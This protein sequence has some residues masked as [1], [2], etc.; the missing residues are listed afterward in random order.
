MTSARSARKDLKD[1]AGHGHIMLCQL[2]RFLPRG[3]CR[4]YRFICSRYIVDAC[5]CKLIAVRHKCY[6]V[7]RFRGLLPKLVDF[8][9]YICVPSI[10]FVAVHILDACHVGSSLHFQRRYMERW[11]Y[12]LSSCEWQLPGPKPLSRKVR[13]KAT[14]DAISFSSV[15][16]ICETL[17]L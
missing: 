12:I 15:A 7:L 13:K 1:R 17:C 11:R 8:F 5:Q 6:H 10:I 9:V 3:V 4:L 2:W 16:S 14:V